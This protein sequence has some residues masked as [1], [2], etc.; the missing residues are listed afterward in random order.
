[1][2][3]AGRYGVSWCDRRNERIE[4][5]RALIVLTMIGV[6]SALAPTAV[7][8]ASPFTWTG[9]AATPNWSA[10]ENWEGGTAPSG[11]GP[12]ALEFPR[13]PGCT[14]TCYYS[15]NDVSGLPVGSLRIDDGDEYWIEGEAITLGAGGLSASPASGSSGPAGDIFKLPIVLDAGQTWSIDGRGNI[16]ENGVLLG[17][18]LTGSSSP[19]TVD[20]GGEPL[21]YLASN[22]EVGQLAIDGTDTSK[23]GVF[24]GAVNLLG[25]QL[26]SQD[27]SPVSLN[28]IFLFGSG[29]LGP[30]TTET[31]E[32][33]VGKSSSPTGIIAASSA[34]FG[35]GSEVTFQ[36]AGTSTAP[37]VDYSQLTS[38]GPIQLGGAS[39][40]VT[41]GPPSPGASC[42]SLTPGQQYT[43]VSTTWSLLG[44]FGNA[45]EGGEIPI[46]FAEACGTREAQKLRVQYHESGTTQTVTA[47]VPETGGLP[48][49]PNHYNTFE[50]P[51]AEGGVHAEMIAAAER[52]A[53]ST[54]R[55]RK[56]KEEA[57]ARMRAAAAVGEVLLTGTGITVQSNGVALV[58]L[59][60]IGNGS[61]AGKLTLSAA[62]TTKEKKKRSRTITIGTDGF[63]LA[64]GKTTI[65][66]VKLNAAGRKLLANAH[67]R[68]A[69]R[70]EIQK[71]TPAPEHTLI[72]NVHL[73]QQKTYGKR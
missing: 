28:H 72:T 57:E 43:L 18:G 26:N 46:R 19:L 55:E 8:T 16:A 34:T 32:L 6:S 5:A 14:N 20:I 64:S 21:V 12:F 25:T 23:A 42:P 40:F 47:T 53:E 67:R 38:Q 41:V 36:I 9:A 73:T 62:S 49:P 48:I 17:G 65:A 50:K 71:L 29:T 3:K 58:K 35:S 68:L 37:G 54:A 1:M 56:A 63:L 31:A 70:L 2:H 13:L 24:N 22:T 52:L 45:R 10:T 33:K 44:A 61:C 60:C 30:L 39:L 4:A 59:D 69:A 11:S 27:G 51:N 66:H 15:R 7:A